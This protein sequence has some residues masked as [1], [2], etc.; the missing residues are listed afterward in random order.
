[1]LQLKIDN[2][3]VIAISYGAKD[4]GLLHIPDHGIVRIGHDIRIFDDNF[5]RFLSLD[6]LM[7][8]GIILSHRFMF[9][10]YYGYYIREIYYMKYQYLM[11]KYGK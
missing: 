5:S 8:K 4:K 10:P 1:M 3:I 7:K 6:E 11:V 2:N 9:E